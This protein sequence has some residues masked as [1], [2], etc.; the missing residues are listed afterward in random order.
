MVQLTGYYKY[1]IT[2]LLIII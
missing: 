1:K 2:G